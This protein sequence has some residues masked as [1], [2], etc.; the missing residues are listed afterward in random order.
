MFFV[1]GRPMAEG[2]GPTTELLGVCLIPLALL[3]DLSGATGYLWAHGLLPVRPVLLTL[4]G[5]GTIFFVVLTRDLRRTAGAELVN[6][7]R[8]HAP[9]VAGLAIVV[10]VRLLW[11]LHPGSLWVASGYYAAFPAYGLVL[12]LLLL[13]V[14]LV[15]GVA[16]H[17]RNSGA[18]ALRGRRGHDGG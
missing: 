7:Y 14:V 5:L 9:I 17:Y 11:I 3:P 10:A 6:C 18:G 12:F 1:S 15:P 16:R 13:P 8:L 4:L 2:R